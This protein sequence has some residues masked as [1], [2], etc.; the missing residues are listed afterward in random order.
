MLA[1]WPAADE[2]G[3]QGTDDQA[4]HDAG[5]AEAHLGL[6]RMDVDVDHLG[7]RFEEQRHHR[8]AVARQEILVGAAHRAGQ[9]LVAHRA[10]VDEEILVLAVGRLSVGRPA[11]PREPEA[12]AIGVDR[13]RIVGELAAHDGG[14][15]LQPR[16][17]ALIEQRR[18]WPPPGRS[19]PAPRFPAGRRSPGWAIASRRIASATWPDSVRGSF[20]NFSRAGV[21]K[22]RSRTSTRVP[23]GC[24]A[25]FGSPLAPPSISRLHAVSAPAG[26]EVM[27]KRLTEAI[28]GSAS[29]RKPSVRMSVRSSSGSLDVQ[30]RST[31][32][33]KLVGDSCRRRRR[34]RK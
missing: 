34:R 3:A 18:R 7:R 2:R 4:A 33:S 17:V 22:N 19:A 28:D 29:P 9:Q 8:M 14:Q 13:Q 15:P 24:A 6:G 5:I 31:A 11:K 20:R 23:G 27:V 25:G 21:A 1:R 16:G 10:A 30:C 26:R 32:S 12:L